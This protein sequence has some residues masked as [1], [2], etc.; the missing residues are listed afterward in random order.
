MYSN[1]LTKIGL[2]NSQSMVYSLLISQGELKG[3]DIAEKLPISRQLVYK[4]LDELSSMNLVEK[5]DLQ[6]ISTFST[7]HPSNLESLIRKQELSLKNSKKEL[8]LAIDDLTSKYNLFYGKPG[9]QV[10]E[11]KEGVKKVLEDSLKTKS[12]ILTFADVEPLITKLEKIN[13]EYVEKRTKLKIKKRA[14]VLDTLYARKYMKKYS[15]KI[16]DTRYISN[17][18]TPPFNSFVE[19]YD[20]KISYITFDNDRLIGIIIQNK[21][22]SDMNRYLFEFAWKKSK[23]I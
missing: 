14:L 17:E 13:N 7:T 6:K 21:A 23:D 19:I 8:D 4:T 5:K 22:I 20:D 9:V 16:R 11:G 1:K 15:G 10:F 12:E 2:N 18:D 3:S